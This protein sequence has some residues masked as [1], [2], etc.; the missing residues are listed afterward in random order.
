ME[1]SRPND[2]RPADQRAT[3]QEHTTNEGERESLSAADASM[4][5]RL[6]ERR[7]SPAFDSTAGNPDEW[8]PNRS[9][10]DR[11]MYES[12]LAAALAHS[13][14]ERVVQ[15][16]AARRQLRTWQALTLGLSL[17]TLFLIA[18]PRQPTPESTPPL[19][20]VPDDLPQ[21]SPPILPPTSPLAGEGTQAG[22]A[23][24]IPPS[25]SAFNYLSLR[26]NWHRHVAD[27]PTTPQPSGEASADRTEPHWRAADYRRLLDEG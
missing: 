23:G 27:W 7:L 15:Q 9:R 18:G 5:Q 26:L 25:P 19:A 20:V 24:S 3:G 16:H 8:G 22:V 13:Q 10:R 4:E 21:A 12:G 14:G 11:L 6:R 1:P 2:N 17:T